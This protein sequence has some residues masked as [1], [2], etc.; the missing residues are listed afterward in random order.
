MIYNRGVE[1]IVL[2]QSYTFVCMLKASHDYCIVG[3]GPAG[4]QVAFHM[5]KQK[6]D[7][8]L[9]ER[10]QPGVKFETQPVHRELISINKRFTSQAN[11]VFNER[12]RLEQ[13]SQR[14][15]GPAHDQVY[16]G[17]LPHS[18]RQVLARLQQDGQAVKTIE[19]KLVLTQIKYNILS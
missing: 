18:V 5:A 10:S 13:H 3:G 14:R 8:I 1:S 17:L 2:I 9:L 7:F 6:T 19:I 11:P 16:Q 15:R 12:Q 4:L